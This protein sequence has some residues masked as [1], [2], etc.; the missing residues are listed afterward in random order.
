MVSVWRWLLSKIAQ[1]NHTEKSI[2]C[3]LQ[4][5]PKKCELYMINSFIS[6]LFQTG[7]IVMP[8]PLYPSIFQLC[9]KWYD[10]HQLWL[11]SVFCCLFFQREVLLCYSSI[12]L[13]LLLCFRDALLGGNCLG[14][15]GKNIQ[16]K[17]HKPVLKYCNQC[18]EQRIST[19]YFQYLSLIYI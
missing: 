18:R 5:A 17:F 11:I 16:M 4:C 19:M 6:V 13:L 15:I 2:S 8:S 14:F 1:K 12:L 9:I 10:Q 7:S 3:Y